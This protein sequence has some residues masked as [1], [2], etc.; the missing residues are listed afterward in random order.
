[1][2]FIHKLLIY[3]DILM[4]ISITFISNKLNYKKIKICGY[5][6]DENNNK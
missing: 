6:G 5:Y 3:I 2:Y 4:I 1:M